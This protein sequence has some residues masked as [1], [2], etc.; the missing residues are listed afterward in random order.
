MKTAEHQIIDRLAALTVPNEAQQAL[1]TLLDHH[2]QA[3]AAWQEAASAT[4]REQAAQQ[5]QAACRADK[6]SQE[7]ARTVRRALGLSTSTRTQGRS[8]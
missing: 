1:G 6:D 2:R 4:S 5:V 3:L 8:V 7:A